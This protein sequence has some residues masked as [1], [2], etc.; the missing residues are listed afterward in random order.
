M[1]WPFRIAQKPD[2]YP[3]DAPERP[4]P[5]RV[6]S[7]RYDINGGILDKQVFHYC[8]PPSEGDLRQ[9]DRHAS[10]EAGDR[11]ICKTCA[12]PRYWTGL[13]WSEIAPTVPQSSGS[14]PKSSDS[15]GSTG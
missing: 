13:I 15:G 2:S 12:K 10:L 9:Q 7:K 1:I 4:P 6:G 3:E 8:N 11:W 5:D 14:S